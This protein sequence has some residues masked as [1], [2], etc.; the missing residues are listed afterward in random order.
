[1]KVTLVTPLLMFV[2]CMIVGRSMATEHTDLNRSLVRVETRGHIADP[3]RPWNRHPVQNLGSGT[4]INNRHVITS[5][6]VVRHAKTVV[7]KHPD[8]RPIRAKVKA[9]A[10]DV[11][12]AL[13]ELVDSSFPKPL[14]AVKLARVLPSSGNSVT[15]IG[16]PHGG[17]THSVTKGVVSRVEFIATSPRNAG[18]M[19][20][21]DAAIN[22][23]NSGGPAFW[24]G[25]C[26]GVAKM[27]MNG[28]NVGFMVS[29]FEI[30]TF[31]DDLKDGRYDGRPQLIASVQPCV[32]RSLRKHF[33][34]SSQHHGLLVSKANSATKLLEGDLIT[35]VGNVA[36][37]DEGLITLP[38]GNKIQLEALL[39]HFVKDHH[40]SLRVIREGK[41]VA[42]LAAVGRRPFV[43]EGATSLPTYAICGPFAVSHVTQLHYAGLQSV[44]QVEQ[45]AAAGSPLLNRLY[46]RPRFDG[47][48]LVIVTAMF[49]SNKLDGYADFT[50]RIVESVNGVHIRNV[51]HLLETI[52]SSKRDTLEF[53]FADFGGDSLVLSRQALAKVTSDVMVDNDIAKPCS[54]DVLAAWTSCLGQ[55]GNDQLVAQ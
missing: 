46:D 43:V 9:I 42:V 1:M 44:V 24:K 23:G 14:K 41:E 18:V 28:E 17:M 52:Q 36:L 47:E 10:H 31:L 5:A 11:D 6:H 37:D 7:L 54:S 4:I 45:F 19:I 39:P 21:V 25:K 30:K 40:V 34:V 3:L 2:F 51:S 29:S 27:A 33:Q 8:C 32:N 55:H 22:P 53:N 50:G 26:I 13:L 12:L 20:Q 16:H 49:D 48:R 38:S 35:H 15:V